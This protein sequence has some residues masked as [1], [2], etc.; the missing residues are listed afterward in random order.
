MNL[1]HYRYLTSNSFTDYKFFSEGPNGKIT[2][3]VRFTKTQGFSNVY[4]L[5]FGD[6]IDGEVGFDDMAITNNADT[7]LVLST[8]A[9]TVI[10]FTNHY[11]SVYVYARGSTTSRTRLYQI[12]IA[13]LFDEISI[14]FEIYG[15]IE[16]DWHNFQRDINYDAFLVKRK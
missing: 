1:P 9:N 15:L 3:I 10:D 2:K 14:Y 6:E 16:E 5:G 12:G 4:N 13:N 11:P 7:N 8:V